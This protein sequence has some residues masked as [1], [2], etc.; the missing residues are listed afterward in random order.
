MMK[1]LNVIIAILTTVLL[2]FVIFTRDPIGF[3]N[4]DICYKMTENELIDV[5]GEPNDKTGVPDDYIIYYYDLMYEEIG[6][7]A[8]FMFYNDKLIRIIFDS[9]DN[10][11]DMQQA[12]NIIK[13]IK[14]KYKNKNYYEQNE[15]IDENSYSIR[16]GQTNGAAGKDIVAEYKNGILSIKAELV[17]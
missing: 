15:H 12:V 8:S 13:D 5:L 1:L 2:S 4:E 9:D 11:C 14:T 16:F 3:I 7:T 6:G 10:A 17:E